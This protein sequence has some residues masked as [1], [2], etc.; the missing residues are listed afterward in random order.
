[1]SHRVGFVGAGPT[2][3]YALNS[4]LQSE[5]KPASITVFERQRRA[6]QGTPY[7]P[8]W[9]DP[10]MLANIASVEIPPL[11]QTLVEWLHEQSDSA[12]RE[13]DVVREDIDERA[14]YPRL[15][16]GEYLAAQF[17]RLVAI[18]REHGIEMEIR[19]RSNVTDVRIAGDHVEVDVC[20]AGQ[21]PA[22]RQFDYL[23]LATGHQWPPDPEARPGYFTSPWPASALSRIR[24]CAVGI[25]G[26]SLSAIDTLVVLANNHGEFTEVDEGRLRWIPN[27]ATEGFSITLFSRKGLLPEAD[28]YHPIPHEPLMYCTPDAIERLVCNS[29]PDELLDR[30]FEL[31]RKE[32]LHCDP[33]YAADVDLTQLSM[34]E[35]CAA[36]FAKR[37]D[38][39]PFEWA[40]QN[41]AE[42][43]AN[44]E[45]KYTVPWRYAILRMHET[46]ALAVP[47][48]SDSDFDRFSRVFKPVFVDDY[49]TVPHESIRRLLALHQAGKLFIERLDQNSRLD[50]HG[51]ASGAAFRR[52]SFVKMFPAFVEATG[53]R[54]LS[55][56]DFPFPSL[57]RQG[58]IQDFE[59]QGQDASGKRGI[60]IDHEFHPIGA[61]QSSDRLFCLSLPY[62]MG[63]HPF[64]QGITSSAEMGDTV[65]IAIRDS[66]SARQQCEQLAE[67]A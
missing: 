57:R 44:A 60:A 54:A 59:S 1:M 2:T 63:K 10:V 49:A 22:R 53:Q 46:I 33:S 11:P 15:V 43:I 7:S 28:F 32:L 38:I 66:E 39:D 67:T 48:L 17:S 65:A 41:L 58:V 30:V 37:A 27:P 40:K 62:L 31:F 23:I 51:P 19:T 29:G 34:E 64:V 47:H 21:A 56:R 14:F 20:T 5:I 4:L 35:F 55:A 18:G 50:I 25:R 45:S 3:I 8:N 6:G 42:A 9:S 52:G 26:T 24:N 12:L 36:Y 16:L 13:L 61:L